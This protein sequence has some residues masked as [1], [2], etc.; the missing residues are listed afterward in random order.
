MRLKWAKLIATR[1]GEAHLGGRGF[2]RACRTLLG[3]SLAL[4]KRCD[5]LGTMPYSRRTAREM[6]LRV[7][8]QVD[9][10]KQPLAEVL[11]DTLTQ[12]LI[13]VANPVEQVIKDARQAVTRAAIEQAPSGATSSGRRIRNAGRAISLELK[14]LA[15][16]LISNS[17][18]YVKRTGEYTTD[19]ALSDAERLVAQCQAS[20]LSTLKRYETERGSVTAI[21]DAAEPFLNRLCEVYA[22]HAPAARDSAIMMSKLV[23]GVT[24]N[25]KAIDKQIADL[26]EGWA[27][28]RQPAVD[29]NILRLATFELSHFTDI[30][31]RV[32]IFEA[33]ELANTYSTEEG[34]RF[35]GGVL[36]A[37][38]EKLGKVSEINVSR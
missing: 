12:A 37:L 23:H 11:A 2:R 13:E 1:D 27:V 5:P 29:R 6:A 38:A 34:A 3:G 25:T 30:E 17:V 22:F 8:F 18:A 19:E 20:F 21:V 16:R 9:V 35:I 28:D 10:G 7:L 15:E 36:N 26:S 14:A 33:V 24:A 31:P 32:T 4:P